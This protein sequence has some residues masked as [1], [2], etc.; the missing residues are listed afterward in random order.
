MKTK[1]G[2]AIVILL[3]LGTL[4]IGCSSESSIKAT[5]EAMPQPSPKL[6]LGEDKFSSKED[7]LSLSLPRGATTQYHSNSIITNDWVFVLSDQVLKE[8]CTYSLTMASLGKSSVKVEIILRQDFQESVL[9]E[10]SFIIES[11][12]YQ[13]Y[14]GQIPGPEVAINDGDQLIIRLTVS[15]DD[16]GIG[17]GIRSSINVLENFTPLSAEVKEERTKALVWLATNSKDRFDPDAEIFVNFKDNL[18]YVVLS[19]ENA[20]WL[21][22]DW[23]TKSEKP[24]FLEWV[25]G[26]FKV[27]EITIEEL[28]D[29]DSWS[30][31]GVI[32]KLNP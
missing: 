29:N 25:N 23:L 5:I 11:D 16:F 24:Y 19:G 32:F 28:K 10:D 9:G 14:E 1:Y 7:I 12:Q 3:A 30:R 31:E 15:G 17:T 20:D 4:L 13:A 26:T 21:V 22:G 2:Y 18:D 8:D 6:Y 27:E